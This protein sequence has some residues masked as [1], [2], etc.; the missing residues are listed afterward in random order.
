M[1][2]NFAITMKE[3]FIKR[4]ITSAVE[5]AYKYFSVITLTGPRQSG[6]TTLTKE[7]FAHLPYYS[8]ENLDVRNF[9]LNDP[10]AFLTQ[11]PEGMIL[12]E[13]QNAPALFSYIQG[14]V[15]DNPDK[16]FILSGSSQ[17]SIIKKITQSL[18][19]RSAV[20]ELLPLSYYE[21]EQQAAAKPLDNL[22]FDGL[23]PAIYAGR[24]IPSLLCEN[25]SRTRRAGTVTG[26]GHDAVSDLYAPMR[27]QGRQP[28]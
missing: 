13:V 23:Y 2:F 26:E 5:E 25:L 16:R 6:K 1:N 24:N 8:L 21:V 22:L 20:L 27:G 28:V 15:D 4:Q 11:H 9:A 19:G 14:I 3:A 10:M 12:D 7:L 18:A 17:F